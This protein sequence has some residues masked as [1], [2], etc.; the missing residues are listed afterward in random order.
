MSKNKSPGK[1]PGDCFLSEQPLSG[2]LDD[3]LRLTFIPVILEYIEFDV[4]ICLLV[5]SDL[6]GFEVYVHCVVLVTFDAI[7]HGIFDS[8]VNLV[9]NILAEHDAHRTF[10]PLLRSIEIIQ[11]YE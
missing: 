7:F 10:L 1:F 6:E 8:F 5:I 4:V 3:R 9:N 2:D 11:S